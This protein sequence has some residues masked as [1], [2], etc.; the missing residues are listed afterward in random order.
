MKR[1]LPALTIA[2]VVIVLLVVFSHADAA[3]IFL[4]N[5]NDTLGTFRTNVNTS[6]TNLNTAVGTPFANPFTPVTHW[7]Q[8]T[9]GTTTAPWFQGSPFSI[10]ASSTAA[11]TNASTTQ[12][13]ATD[14]WFTGLT[15]GGLA[16]DASGKVYRG[17]TTTDSCASG[18]TCTYLGS[19][20]SFSLS[21]INAGVLG[22]VVNGAVPT[23]QATSTLYGAVQNGKILAGLGG[24]LQYVATSTDSC[25]T[26]VTCT[27]SGGVNSFSIGTN[28]L[29]L[30]Q[31]PQISANRLWGN[32]SGATAN[33]GEVSTSSLFAAGT[34]GQ[35]LTYTSAGTWILSSTSTAGT[36]LTYTG[37]AFNVNS[38]QSI[39]TL[40]NLGTNGF[41]QTSGSNGTLGVQ[42]YP[43]TVAQGCTNATVLPNN[44]IIGS[45]ST[46][47]GLIAT[48]TGQLT[49][50]NILATTTAT[51][52]FNGAL[53]LGTTTSGARNGPFT[54]FGNFI[55]VCNTCSNATQGGNTLTVANF[56]NGPAGISLFAA[57][58][59]A[60]VPTA[61]VSGATIGLFGARG[62]GSTLW[63]TGSKAAIQF[64]TSQAW[65]DSN[66]GTLMTF[67]VTPNNSTTRTEAFRVDQT[68]FVGIAST[69]P[70]GLLSVN[71]NALGS[72][73]P[74]FVVGS[75]T[76]THF[77]V[78][79]AGRVA[80]GTSTIPT[81]SWA[82]YASTTIMSYEARESTSTSQTVDFSTSNQSL[83]QIG[84]AGVTISFINLI[85]GATKRIVV[86]NPHVGTAGTITWPNGGTLMWAGGTAPVQTTTLDKIDIYSCVV[87]AGTSTL[88]A[89]TAKAIC[90]PSL[91]T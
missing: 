17:A 54:P 15:S 36:G 30:S 44:A 55:S 56:G 32:I 11:F 76:M 20:E 65:T 53:V 21:T 63:A 62:F 78:T 88:A 83:V 61:T 91:N 9:A 49:V 12:F 73:V 46:G 10:F 67:E 3:T 42:T 16:V 43:C 38:S 28:A 33:A 45:N 57:S 27:Y 48:G 59:T 2:T 4:T 47:L 70:W 79:G 64:M 81:G 72:G 6:L 19:T 25:G 31:L 1:G 66:Q 14:Q 58:G 7:G 75:S 77:L 34:A 29:T 69:T 39:A 85:P 71:P 8:N 84:T 35:V 60:A 18:V 90:A 50:G 37:S 87:T 52:T 82:L 51:S 68:G 74:E 13:T 26:G 22:A 5:S 40:S 86:T 41:V 23:S 80:I 89:P 24:T